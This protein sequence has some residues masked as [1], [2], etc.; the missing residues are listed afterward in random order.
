MTP[1]V[2]SSCGSTAPRAPGARSPSSAAAPPN[3][4]G[5]RLVCLERPGVGDSTDHVY[6]HLRDMSDDVAIVADR[7]GH[8]RFMVAGLSG[9][10]P[11]ALACAHDEPY[12]VVAITR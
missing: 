3:G 6:P 11:Y 4:I 12:G 1:P 2:R 10:G 9:G 8:D 5:L 7:L